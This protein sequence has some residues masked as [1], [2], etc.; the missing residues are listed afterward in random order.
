MSYNSRNGLSDSTIARVLLFGSKPW[1]L[2]GL[3]YL[4]LF[5]AMSTYELFEGTYRNSL[6]HVYKLFSAYFH[7][8]YSG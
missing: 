5:T 8:L 4:R 3:A 7:K 2:F 1:D 6:L